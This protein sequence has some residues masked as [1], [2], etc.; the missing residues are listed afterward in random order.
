MRR[1]V[2]P[3]LLDRLPAAHPDAVHSR[4]D[5]RRLNAAMRNVSHLAAP[6]RSI[7]PPAHMM[8]LGAGDGSVSLRVATRLEWRNTRITLVDRTPA[9]SAETLR[10]FHER[11]C[12]ATVRVED[13]LAG[14]P[15]GADV[16]ITNLFLHHFQ[17][18]QLRR[19]LEAVARRCTM[20]V[21]CEP[22][23]ALRALLASRCVGALGCNAVTRHDA[24]ASVHAGFASH[25]LSRL[26]PGGGGWLLVEE[27]AGLF[28]H[29]FVA[30]RV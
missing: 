22:R 27:A 17:D 5:L 10:A 24:V 2:E 23:R 7:D 28:G 1:L 30:T 6:L 25:E 4:N 29:R 20:F 3:E 8:D 9:V 13:V 16:I 21:A 19:L 26:W 15:D 12:P 11:G 18:E 14:L